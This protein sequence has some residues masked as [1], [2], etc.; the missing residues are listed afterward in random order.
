MWELIDFVAWCFESE[1]NLASTISGKLTAVQHFHRLEASVELDLSSPMLKCALRGIAR[2]HVAMGT[3]R[4]V[5][6]PV[7]WQMLLDGESASRNWGEGGRVT[8]LC[9]CLSYLFI[10]RSD[11]VFANDAGR[12]HEAH[13]LTRADVAL[14]A[15]EL[16]L[17]FSHYRR[18]DRVEMRFRGHKAD[19]EQKGNVR[20]RTRDEVAGPQSGVRARGGAVA[21]VVELLSC[22]ATLPDS[23]PLAS[24][25]SGRAVRVVRYSAALRAVREVVEKSGRNPQEYALHSL[26]IGGA[27]ALA[28]GG[29]I[30][31]R[32]I[33]R[34]GKWR[35]DA[36]KLYARNNVEDSRRVSQK[37]TDG[38]RI[39]SRQPG[40]GTVWGTHS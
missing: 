27:T 32:V 33:Q 23:A 26:R 17:G 11:E 12:V 16:Q 37:L 6:L 35:S 2:N 15:G 8:W 36:Y 29:D 9:L 34:E 5:R 7:S 20:V 28:S 30:A 3:V 10:T 40:E 18:A 22:H 19:Q 21:L 39:V 1:G 38:S 31:E 24:Y 14:F 13:C 4:R 25:R